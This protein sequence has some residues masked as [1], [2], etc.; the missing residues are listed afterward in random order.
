MKEIYTPDQNSPTE[1]EALLAAEILSRFPVGRLPLSIYTEMARLNALT[2]YEHVTFR[3]DDEGGLQ[4]LLSQRGPNDPWWPNE[5]HSPGVMVTSTDSSFED[6]HQRL[7][8]T[9]LGE[10]MNA[11]DPCCVTSLPLDTARGKEIAYISWSFVS[12]GEPMKG[13]FFDID[14]L[15]NDLIGH[16]YP[17]LEAAIGDFNK[18]N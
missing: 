4:V 10:N 18:N 14:N 2:A 7:V 17:I 3:E 13:Q 9:E 8:E 1:K 15:P 12:D 16:H 5:W 6:V 11:S